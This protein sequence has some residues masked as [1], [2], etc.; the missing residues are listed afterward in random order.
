MPTHIGDSIDTE[1]SLQLI[2]TYLLRHEHSL[3]FTDLKTATYMSYNISLLMGMRISLRPAEQRENLVNE[4]VRMLS[5]YMG[6][7]VSKDLTL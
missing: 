3:A 6:C 7:T 5:L 2:D 1:R 4:V